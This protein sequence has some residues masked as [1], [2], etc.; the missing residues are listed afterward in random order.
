MPN[1]YNARLQSQ[2]VSYF[3][4]SFFSMIAKLIHLSPLQLIIFIFLILPPSLLS[5]TLHAKPGCLDRCG[6]LLIPYPFGVGE[7]C[8]LNP[9]FDINCDSSTD[10]PKAYLS[11]MKKQ[12]IEFDQ[13]Y[14]R[15][16][17]PYTISACYD[18]DLSTED[19]HSMSVNF[20]GTPYMLPYGNVLTA[21]GCDDMMLQSNESAVLGGCSAFCPGKS[22]AGFGDCHFNG[23]CHQKLGY[24]NCQNSKVNILRINYIICSYFFYLSINTRSQYLKYASSISI[25]STYL[26]HSNLINLYEIRIKIIKYSFLSNSH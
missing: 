17:N 18:E 23:C 9:Y 7:N 12:V 1:L 13:S 21:I 24:G 3:K 22:D 16:L 19:K 8:S 14:I 4:P 25:F 5:A 20:S 2:V 15:L 11:I 6:D 26:M 10:P